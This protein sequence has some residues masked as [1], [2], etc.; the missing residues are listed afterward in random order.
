M[1][2][3]KEYGSFI[4]HRLY[5]YH[6][7]NDG[8][9]FVLPT[10]MAYFFFTFKLN[11]FQAGLI[12]GFNAL[13]TVILQIFIG[14]YTDKYS[15]ILMK[16]GLFIL[17]IA[18]FLMIFSMDFFS[19]LIFATF[20]GIA[21]AFQHS[22]SYAT[23]SRLFPDEKR[24]IMIGHQGSAGDLGKCVAVFT[25][26]IMMIIFSSWQI[27]LLFWSL[28]TLLVF[29][30]ISYNFRN[31]KFED[32]FVDFNGTGINSVE[33]SEQNT[34][35]FLIF[36]ITSCY[37]LISGVFALIIINLATYLR[38]E[39]TGPVSEYSGLI[40]GYT[41]IFGAMG[42]ALSGRVK[43][44]FGM[45][46]SIIILSIVLICIF[47][48]Y[49]FLNP[50]DLV[51]TLVFFGVIAILLFLIYPQLLAAVNSITHTKKIGFGY[52][53]M[54]SIGWFGNFLFSLIGGYFAS[55]YSANM[56]FIIAIILLFFI[57]ATALVLKLKYRM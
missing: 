4:Q 17:A 55:L 34:E 10:L 43:S 18:S 28:L 35:K 51:S 20:S 30:V 46:S 9:S 22:I 21:L 23:T 37:I 54:L 24:D 5:L 31:I 1:K 48:L 52:G 19:L 36:L 33:E 57:I 16:I 2:K 13:A 32:Y 56:F 42:S 38:V 7:L 29:I 44:K 41:L 25:S 39:K 12:F 27:V 45:G 14:Y 26:S 3:E 53:L 50:N 8:I 49:I 47:S 6:F 15:E 40:L 11:W